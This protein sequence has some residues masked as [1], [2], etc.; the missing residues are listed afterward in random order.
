MADEQPDEGFVDDSEEEE[1]TQAP[2]A[3]EAEQEPTEEDEE[4]S[5]EQTESPAEVETVEYEGQEYNI[6]PELKEAFL[7]NKDY[8]TKTQEMAE[9]RKD[10]ETDRQRF[11]E[12]IQLQTAHTEAYTHLGIV[13]Q[14]LAQ[15]NEIDWNTLAAQ[16]PNATQQ[17]Q[18]QV[19][20]LREQRTQA[21]EK[22]QSL[23]AE[24]QQHVHNQTAKEVEQNRAKIERS[25]PNWSSETEKAVFEFGIQSGLSES[26]L[27]GTNYDP[28]LIGI[29]N[30]ARLFDELQQKQSGKKPK[31]SEPVPQATRVTPK[32]TVK[33]GLHDNLSIDEWV[34]R[35][36]AHI[37]KRG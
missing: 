21:Q 19:S 13:D 6:P 15:Y 23:H 2:E 28:V 8:T 11:Q 9:Q 20:A 10:L 4:D 12:A 34:K 29:L 17:A 33:T 3:K 32:R 35:R 31:K 22:L 18:I 14:Q 30:K 24:T 36:E 16:D 26:Q 27:A 5:E 1:S 37:A 25:V 7:K